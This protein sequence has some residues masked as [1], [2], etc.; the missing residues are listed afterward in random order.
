MADGGTVRVLQQ[1]VR[2]ARQNESHRG[3]MKRF[4]AWLAERDPPR[5][6]LAFVALCNGGDATFEEALEIASAYSSERFLASQTLSVSGMKKVAAAAAAFFGPGGDFPR[7]RNPWAT[8]VLKTLKKGARRKALL[9]GVGGKTAFT[10]SLEQ[11][12]GMILAL[13]VM[14]EAVRC[15]R[16]C[17]VVPVRAAD[18]HASLPLSPLHSRFLNSNRR[19]LRRATICGAHGC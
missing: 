5:T 8:D 19:H 12:S 4:E 6:L 13:E 18:A 11:L 3:E 15:A 17:L 16:C 9:M 10:L 1:S 14:A 7:T 2:Q